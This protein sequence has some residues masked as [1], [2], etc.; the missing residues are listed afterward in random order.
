MTVHGYILNL[1][2]GVFGVC[3]RK[4]LI[5]LGTIHIKVD[6]GMSRNGCQPHELPQLIEVLLHD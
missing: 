4:D 1:F 5:A 6:T 2:S 3:C